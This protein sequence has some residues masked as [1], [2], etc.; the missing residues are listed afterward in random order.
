MS[1]NVPL[2]PYL[3]VVRDANGDPMTHEN[4]PSRYALK[5]VQSDTGRLLPTIGMIWEF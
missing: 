2:M 5:R 4:D 1:S 3:T